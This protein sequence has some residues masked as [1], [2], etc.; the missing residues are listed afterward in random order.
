MT[1][2]KEKER[3]KPSILILSRNPFVVGVLVP[4][5]WS[6][7]LTIDRTRAAGVTLA[8]EIVHSKGNESLQNSDRYRPCPEGSVIQY[9]T[10]G[11]CAL[12]YR[13]ALTYRGFCN[14]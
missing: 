7:L 4:G 2:L 14:F 5:I 8:P 10:S 6:E 11:V 9:D 1:H 13:I 12:A 3:K